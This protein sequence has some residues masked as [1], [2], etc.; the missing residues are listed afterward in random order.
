MLFLFPFAWSL[1]F[2]FIVVFMTVSEDK[3]AVH[4]ILGGFERQAD[5]AEQAS[6]DTYDPPSNG[7]LSEGQVA[8]YSRTL[9]PTAEFCE[10]LGRKLEKMEDNG[11]ASFGDMFSDGGTQLRAVPRLS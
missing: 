1:A 9:Q 8:A 3:R 11:G 10:R 4:F 5:F 7:R 6:R 2:V